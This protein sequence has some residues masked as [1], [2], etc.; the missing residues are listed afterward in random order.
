[1]ARVRDI[2]TVSVRTK[3]LVPVLFIVVAVFAAILYGAALVLEAQ[4]H[5]YSRRIGRRVSSAVA[6]G[7][8]SALMTGR[9]TEA[10]EAIRVMLSEADLP[11]SQ[12]AIR[13]L[14]GAYWIRGGDNT[15]PPHSFAL[16]PSLKENSSR[17]FS[18]GAA[19]FI[20]T[21]SVLPNEPECQSCHSPATRVLGYLEV[22]LPVVWVRQRHQATLT[23]IA[24]IAGLT[25][26][27]LAVAIV[28]SVQIA[29]VTPIKGLASAM[30]VVKGGHRDVQVEAGPEDEIGML[31]R[32]FNEMV[33][34]VAEAEHSL[35]EKEHQ[36]AR[37]EKLAGIGLMAAGIAH[38]INN[39]LTAVSMAAESI[40]LPNATQEQRQRLSA[41]IL[42]GTRRIQDIVAELLTLDQKRALNVTEQDVAEIVHAAL[43]GRQIPGNIT[44]HAS[45]APDLP[46]VH[47]D[48]ERIVRAI[49]NL[50][51]NAL[52]AMPDGGE[53]TLSAEAGKGEVLIDIKDTGGGIAPEHLHRIFDPFFSTREVGEGFG[54]G[55]AFA[56]AVVK[57][58]GGDITVSSEPGRGTAFTISLPVEPGANPEEPGGSRDVSEMEE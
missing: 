7:L 10:Q 41:Y 19:R 8:H 38:E 26:L 37:A 40:N 43:A 33:D 49:G 42:E 13:K 52:Q 18:V 45:L 27:L 54:L 31:S 24:V 21:T 46:K 53:L 20:N 6:G 29:V 30:T 47:V 22:D 5:E 3:I 32:R 51:K 16:K 55:L 44:V 25:L 17:E 23:A 39:P 56:H 58:H 50:V 12:I 36:L 14:D 28:L 35:V 48:W 57:Q 15:I 34:E 9:K 2:R 1:M 11:P 4:R